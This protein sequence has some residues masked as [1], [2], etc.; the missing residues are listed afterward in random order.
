MLLAI[1]RGHRHWAAVSL[2]VW[3][4]LVTIVSA[5]AL[6]VIRRPK[7][8]AMHKAI[9]RIW[10]ALVFATALITLFVVGVDDGG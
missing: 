4:H 8:G 6:T 1:G 10:V 7:G 9:G 2:L 3:A 5:L